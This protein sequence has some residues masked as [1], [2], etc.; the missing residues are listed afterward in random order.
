MPPCSPDPPAFV[1]ALAHCAR[2]EIKETPVGSGLF[3]C[4]SAT[5]GDRGLKE[6]TVDGDPTGSSFA[7]T[8]HE[9]L[10]WSI[11]CGVAHLSVMCLCFFLFL[12]PS[13]PRL[14][15]RESE[16]AARWE[17]DSSGYLYR[18]W[19][20]NTGIACSPMMNLHCVNMFSQLL[21][22]FRGHCS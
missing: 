13:R 9:L 11:F 15:H 12:F 8:A 6:Q 7:H 16:S 19:T 14:S 17:H 5:V 2:D 10:K 18:I 20:I 1:V 22:R 3:L 21:G 4:R